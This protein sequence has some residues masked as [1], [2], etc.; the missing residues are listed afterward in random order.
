MIIPDG[1]G[2]T[3]RQLVSK[4]IATKTGV[5]HTTR[6]GYGTVINLL[7]EDPFGAQGG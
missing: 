3:V 5:K 4:Y 7:E 2:L 6:A 1:G